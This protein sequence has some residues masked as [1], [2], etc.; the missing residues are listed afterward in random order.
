M[1][2]KL[3]NKLFVF[4]AWILSSIL[5]FWLMVAS[6]D[7]LIAI[8]ATFYVRDSMPRAWRARFYDKFYFIASG[9][10]FLIFIF[11][12]EGYFSDGAEE[13]DL[14]RRLTKTTGIELL[15]LL[16][17]D[18]ISWLAEGI[19]GQFAL[20]L[21]IGEFAGGALLLGYAIWVKRRAANVKRQRAKI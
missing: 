14:F 18:L 7:S 4:F 6:R 5:G 11:A 21:L 9:I 16:G 17:C 8:L 12:I 10:A 19:Q 20:L 13:Q 1:K 3:L 15:V 2:Q